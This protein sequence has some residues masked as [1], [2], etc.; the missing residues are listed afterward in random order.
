MQ[1]GILA[2]LI[3]GRALLSVFMICNFAAHAHVPAQQGNA[4]A[5]PTLVMH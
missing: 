1:M 5:Y 2:M 4:A 3:V